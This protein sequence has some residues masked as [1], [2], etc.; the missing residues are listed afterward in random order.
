MAVTDCHRPPCR[1][2]PFGIECEAEGAG[3]IG[4]SLRGAAR[5]IANC[6]LLRRVRDSPKRK[7]RR[8]NIT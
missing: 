3:E 7:G 6:H 1:R 5:R 2:Y 8:G 4:T